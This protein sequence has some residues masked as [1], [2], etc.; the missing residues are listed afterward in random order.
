MA[1]GKEYIGRVK[2]PAF[3]LRDDGSGIGAGIYDR[4]GPRMRPV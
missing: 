3:E 4:A 2:A 1:V